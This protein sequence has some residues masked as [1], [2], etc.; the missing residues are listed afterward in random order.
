MPAGICRV[1][2]SRIHANLARSTRDRNGLPL[3]AN[4]LTSNPDRSAL[5]FRLR[6]AVEPNHRRPERLPFRVH[7]ERQARHSVDPDRSNIIRLDPRD[8]QDM[9]GGNAERRGTSP[10]RPARHTKVLGI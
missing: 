2:D 7:R 9:A 5:G 6:T 10:L 4:W 1:R 8:R 3:I